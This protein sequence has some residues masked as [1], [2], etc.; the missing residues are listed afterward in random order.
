MR[1]T[2]GVHWDA[3]AMALA[4]ASGKTRRIQELLKTRGVLRTQKPA[5][6]QA[7]RLPRDLEI[8]RAQDLRSA[9]LLAV[10]LQLA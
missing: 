1:R 5:K 9:F 2:S 7:A 4:R 6:T 3:R 8:R 10:E